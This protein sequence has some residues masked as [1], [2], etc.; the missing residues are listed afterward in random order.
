MGKCIHCGHSV[1]FLRSKHSECV[2]Q[3]N[4]AQQL[5]R[6][7]V[8][9][10]IQGS[11][12]AAQLRSRLLPIAREG[13][14]KPNELD[15]AMVDG[16]VCAVES[17]LE[18]GLLSRDEESRLALFSARSGI[19]S[20]LMRHPMY[21]QLNKATVLRELAEGNMPSLPTF[22]EPLP[23]NLQK[24][25][26]VIWAFSDTEYLEDQIK[27]EIVGRSHGVS[28]RIMKGVYYRVGAFKGRP[29]TKQERVSLGLGTLFVTTKHLYFAGSQ[30]SF[31]VPYSKIVAFEHY[32]DGIG[33]TRD[34]ASAKPQTFVTK[35]G[36]FTC[37]LI[38]QIAEQ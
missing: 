6:Q 20:E 7:T 29:V 3:H 12:D 31:R 19:G 32:S 11:D 34:A 36:W 9:Q 8:M 33:I 2:E 22:R 23:I 21:V 28:L 17:F 26:S 38:A 24:G 35:D 15:A 14:V 25:E 13:Y 30:K 37:N 5:L 1:G 16:W 10:C 18:D 4:R 27:R